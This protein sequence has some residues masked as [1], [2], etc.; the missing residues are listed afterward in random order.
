M[1]IKFTVENFLSFMDKS[2]LNLEAGSI[3]EFSKNTFSD[4]VGTQDIRLLKSTFLWGGNSAGKSN[5][6]KA[7]LAMKNMVLHSAKDQQLSITGNIIPFLLNRKTADAPTTF[8]STFLIDRTCYRYGFTADSKKIHVEWLYVIQKRKEENIFFRTGANVDID[9]RFPPDQKQKLKFLID[10]TRSDS[11]FLSVLSQ[12]NIDFALNIIKWY[13]DNIIYIDNELDANIEE[14]TV[15]Y[16]AD[17]L[18]NPEYKKLIYFILEKAELGFYSIE[19]ELND[20]LIKTP[21]N[22]SINTI[23]YGGTPGKYTIKTKH[24]IY[25]EQLQPVGEVYFDLLKQESAGTKKFLELLGP[26]VKTILEGKR[27]WI[28]E[29]DAQLHIML[30]DLIIKLLHNSPFNINGAQFIITTHNSHILK[31]LRRDQ[32]IMLDKDKYG[33]STIGSVYTSKS[34]IRGDVIFD[35]E[36]LLGTL[37]GVPKKRQLS[38]FDNDDDE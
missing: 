5:F 16:T 19:E 1:L 24:I 3:R 28:D 7:F 33:A 37:G 11:L 36:Y 10:M 23:L 4:K 30:M 20:K 13:Q 21:S 26:I 8:E 18:K 32:M 15:S 35:K 9:K 14:G 34:G 12:F 31:K 6:L 29:L 22:N 2:S 17:L 38:L 25:N 27:M